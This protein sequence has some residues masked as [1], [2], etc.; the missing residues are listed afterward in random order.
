[1]LNILLLTTF[2]C[3]AAVPCHEW[4]VVTGEP[5]QATTVCTRTAPDDIVTWH[6]EGGVASWRGV[7]PAPFDVTV[8]QASGGPVAALP[9]A[10]G[11]FPLTIANTSQ[12]VI[13]VVGA[14]IPCSC[15]ESVLLHLPRSLV[16]APGI[17]SLAF[18]GTISL[19]CLGALVLAIVRRPRRQRANAGKVRDVEAETLCRG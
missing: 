12:G 11:G 9:F 10:A 2:T 6:K 7:T 13:T 14:V 1:M 5:Y 17:G 15:T 19:I 8:L 3:V 18:A 4:L 16:S